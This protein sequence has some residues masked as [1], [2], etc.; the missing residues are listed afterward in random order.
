MVTVINT[1]LVKDRVT[2]NEWSEAGG[3]GFSTLLA[4]DVAVVYFSF[5]AG[6][7]FC[8]SLLEVTRRNGENRSLL[9]VL[10]REERRY[11]T[12]SFDPIRVT[13]ST[14]RCSIVGVR[15][16]DPP[17][18]RTQTMKPHFSIIRYVL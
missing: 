3:E 14:V 4:V 7:W 10:L 16:F 11:I 13:T 1:L 18:P 9:L 12:E 17:Q 8:N 5:P 6:K 15:K 2:P